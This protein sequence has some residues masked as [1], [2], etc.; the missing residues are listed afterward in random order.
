M[1]IKSEVRLPLAAT[2]LLVWWFFCWL[3]TGVWFDR[4]AQESYQNERLQAEDFVAQAS[5]SFNRILKSRSGGPRVL[6]RDPRIQ[7]VLARY[8]TS[9]TIPQASE[10]ERRT[11]WGTDPELIQIN[12]ELKL[13]AKDMGLDLLV[14]LDTHGYCLAASN[15][16]SAQSIVGAYYGDR[17]A[18]QT[19]RQGRT[20]ALSSVEKKMGSTSLSIYTPVME[21]ERF[22]GVA[23]GGNAL[24]PF[25]NLLDQD[26]AFLTD[27]NG[28]V[29]LARNPTFM[30]QTLPDSHV[31]RLDAATRQVLYQRTEF[32]ALPLASAADERFPELLRVPG[33]LAPALLRS[34]SVADGVLS[35]NVLWPMPQLMTQA[36]H[37]VWSACAFGLIGSLLMLLLIVF[38]GRRREQHVMAQALAQREQHATQSSDFLNQIVNTIADPLVVKDQQHRWV[39]V[40][41][42]FCKFMGH[43]QEYFIGKT[44]HDIF[45]EHQARR[46]QDT[47]ERI[48]ASDTECITEEKLTDSRGITH[49]VVI[50][51]AP[52]T[53]THGNHFLVG[54]LS[55][56]T[57]RKQV[58]RLLRAREREFSSLTENLPVAV[59]RYDSE[60]RRR[61][62][63]PSAE[64]MLHGSPA[65][66]LGNEPGGPTVPASPAMIAHYR[67]K[68]EEVLATNTMRELDFVLDE[69]PIDC[70]EHYEVRFVPEHDTDGQT[71]GVLAIWYDIT[72]RKRLEGELKQREIEFRSLAESS[73]DFMVRYDRNGQHLYLNDRLLSLLELA[74]ADELIGKRPSEVWPDGRFAEL[75]RAVTQ[76][77]ESA[78]QVDIELI[79]PVAQSAFRYHQIFVVPERDASG[80]IIGAIAF[81]REI[82]AIREAERK[83]AHFIDNLP[84]LAY[85]FS[86]SPEGHG[87]F[88]YVS[89]AIEDIYGLKPED[90]KNNMAALH[91]LAHP[92]DQPR[93]EAAI[94]E[95]ARTMKP[96]QI[97]S[98]VCRPSLPERWLDVRSVP[99]KQIDGS[100]VWYGLML[101][102][103]E[104]KQ[105]ENELKQREAEFHALADNLPDPVFRYDRNC[106]RVYVNPAAERITAMSKEQLLGHLPITCLTVTPED[107][108][109][110]MTG[111][112]EVVATGERRSFSVGYISSDGSNKEHQ[113]LLVPE[114]DANGQVSTVLTMAHD[115]S[116]LRKAE[117]HAASF[118]ANMPGFAYTLRASPD[119]HMS[120]PFVS[121]G[122]EDIYGLRPEDVRDDASLLYDMEHPED[123]P[124]VDAASALANQTLQPFQ[125]EF[126]VQ[127][128]GHPLRWIENRSM[129]ERQANGELL[130]H[131]IMLDITERKR[132][133]E[134][135]TNSESRYRNSNSLLTSMLDSPSRMYIY[136]L[137]RNYRYL[138][139]NDQFRAAAQRAWGADIAV[140]MNMLDGINTEAHREF[141]RKGFDH[142]L[143]GHSFTLESHETFTRNGVTVHEYH[144]NYGSPIRN[145]QGDIVGLTVFAINITERKR[146]EAQLT[147]AL[148][149]SNGIINA[150]PDLLFEVNRD[151][152]YLNVWTKNPERLAA[153]KE[154]L[155]GRTVHEVM[156]PE[157]AAVAMAALSEADQNGTSFGKVICLELPQGKS[158]FEQSVS[159]KSGATTSDDRFLVLSREVTERKRMELALAASEEKHRVVF[160]FA[161][162][163][164]FLHRIL[165]R[166][167]QTEFI[168]HDLNRQGC[169]LWGHSRADI[170]SGQFDLLAMSN[171]PYTLEEATRRNLLAAAGQPQLFDWELKRGDGSTSWCEVSL[172]RIQIGGEPFLLAMMRDLNERKR[173]EQQLQEALEFSNGIINAIPD[174][175][176]EIDRHGRYLNIWAQN[177]DVQAEKKSM[178]L[179]KTFNE[180]LTP[181]NAAASMAILRQADENGFASGPPMCIVQADGESRW[182]E[183]S[184]RKKFGRTPKEVT[185]L[186]L[187]RD[188]TSI[189]RAEESLRKS[190]DILRALAVHKETEREKERK[191][192]AYKIHEDLAQNLAALRMNLSF[193]KMDGGHAAHA[194]EIKTLNDITLHC[195]TRIRD[196]VS[197]L[198]PTVLDL[199]LVPA[200]QWLIDDFKGIGFQF[201][202]A[203]QEDIPLSDE[204]ATVLFRAAQE[205]LLNVALHAGATHVRVA[206][207]ELD[208][209]CRLTISDNGCGFDTFAPHQQGH[210]GLIG[211]TEQT[212]HLG[213]AVAIHSQPGQ[214]SVLTILMPSALP[215]PLKEI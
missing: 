148:E 202:V 24:A 78:L 92:D 87:F 62:L 143:A 153:P 27:T 179:G 71:I 42:A 158:W 79:Q 120:L 61:Y 182:Y 165:E 90:V 55:D 21:Q 104:R 200:L 11:R 149:F 131:G 130:W 72:E 16:D 115:V 194:T 26:D 51:K 136:A 126:R 53:D 111:I 82:T 36:Q 215:Q 60:C 192:L 34:H 13:M 184:V 110:L 100:I 171:P 145:D 209:N 86:L 138:A 14:L 52:Y 58:E 40:N 213:G 4:R 41:Q 159:K 22:M 49:I 30:L 118:F 38:S 150:I 207:D 144:D 128:P 12:S 124:R 74:S 98:R 8:A 43:P 25:A 203:L 107:S 97:E 142:V 166:D 63:N 37:R 137:D 212:R 109:K 28:V 199:G 155:L 64:K 119:G 214:G 135:L 54:V 116:A 68:M 69:L 67:T 56:I 10:A 103:T 99:E 160:E 113:G 204:A 141:C 139:F 193:L 50:K 88:P 114:F 117:R 15:A 46:L 140:G 161:N 177:P 208:G 29:L 17:E 183:H 173:N 134:A 85:T 147:E 32:S 172:R 129:P 210:F 205:A 57:E 162:D 91:A 33:R 89:N 167:G 191:E 176:F 132:M 122:I 125:A 102:I 5:P 96:V 189:K 186:A 105:L 201:D 77:M 133:E 108:V 168:L 66:L 9:P 198:R 18:F 80:L 123:R 127:R 65:E 95:S 151:G 146:I 44:V 112:R 93:I 196:I 35:V 174:V 180:V 197:V 154:L 163:G 1:T 185:F 76:A 20:S 94:A 45:P 3:A 190:H 48:L 106:R 121:S 170:L 195:I 101:D 6:A 81:G 39:L 73:P 188:I 206:L 83:L 2:L 156:P 178:L 164:I 84:G 181:E 75:E 59:I 7:R 70:Q 175:L 31:N 187:S 169:E 152:R 23:S 157:E 211:L 47:D 19:A